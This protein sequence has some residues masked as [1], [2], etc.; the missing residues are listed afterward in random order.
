MRKEEPLDEQDKKILVSINKLKDNNLMRIA[1][2]VGLSKSAIH[3]RIKKLTDMGILKGFVPQLDTELLP[4]QFTAIS[5]IR[6]QY[7]PNYHKD[8]AKKLSAVSGVCA[9]YFV[10]GENDF[11]VILK[12]RTRDELE[13]SVAHF[14][15]I[16]GVERSNT[17]LSL[18]TEFEDISKFYKL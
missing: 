12:A 8:I 6:A 2:S 10:L 9:V 1:K 15:M 4:K 13:D 18:S 11:I 16:E 17:V 3:K 7:G 14:N 5:M